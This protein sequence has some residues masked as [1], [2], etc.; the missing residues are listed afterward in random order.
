M[1]NAFRLTEQHKSNKQSIGKAQPTTPIRKDRNAQPPMGVKRNPSAFKPLVAPRTPTQPI[2]VDHTRAPLAP[3]RLN[4]V[5]VQ[6][7]FPPPNAP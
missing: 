7:N 3:I 4:L 2:V 6:R 1:F 5:A